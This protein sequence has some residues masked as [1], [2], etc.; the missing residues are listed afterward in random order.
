[1]R[2]EESVRLL[3]SI[4]IVKQQRAIVCDHRFGRLP[5]RKDSAVAHRADGAQ[6]AGP[7][8][9]IKNLLAQRLPAPP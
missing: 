7:S 9:A 6:A 3:M 5:N 2:M 1:M 8:R 4:L